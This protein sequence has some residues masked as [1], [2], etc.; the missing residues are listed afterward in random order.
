MIGF[1]PD[2]YPDELFYSACARYAKRLNYPNKLSAIIDLLGKKG[3]SATVDIPTRLDHFLSVIQTGEYSAEEIINDHTLFPFY[4]PFIT[5]ERSKI[6]REEIKQ[7]DDNRLRT[8]LAINI[9]QIGQPEYLRF[10][11]LCAESDR[12][13]FGET[14]WHRLHQLSA[15]LVCSEHRCFLENSPVRWNQ[16][17]GKVLHSAEEFISLKKPRFLD[18]S[19]LHDRLFIKIAEDARWLLNQSHLSLPNDDLRARYYNILLKMKYAWY[20]SRIKST[21]L[22]ADFLAYYPREFLDELGCADKSGEFLWLARM[23]EKKPKFVFHHPLRHLLLLNF[24]N[25]S[26]EK[27]FH[28]FVEFKPFADSP[29]PC[30]NPV[31]SHYKELIIKDCQIKDSQDKNKNRGRPL[32][33]FKCGCGFV[34]RRLGSDGSAEDKFRYDSVLEYGS[35]WESR[36]AEDWANLN[37]SLSEIARRF[38]TTNHL[39]VRHAIRL[40]LPMNTENT[41]QIE[42]YARHRSP[43]N[44]LSQNL[45][46]YR[47][48][49]ERVIT[50]HP[51]L[52]RK[53][54]L[55][56][57]KFLYQWLMRNDSDWFEKHLPAPLEADKKKDILNWK[58]IDRQL[59]EKVKRV[60][61]EILS[62]PKPTRVSITEIIKRTGNKN[63]LE[64]ADE[65]LPLTSELLEKSLESLEAFMLRKLKWAEEQYV[66]EKVMP[67]RNQ[68]MCR[69]AIRNGTT[70]NSPIIQKEVMETLERIRRRLF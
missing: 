39:I 52:N 31:S 40:N 17:V 29:Y 28:N 63:W 54:L 24:L 67:T 6:I 11:S 70:N 25:V 44:Y 50:K 51:K 45:K 1:F 61:R 42:G 30:L 69:A 38:Q 3:V 18:E 16:R 35:V 68:L 37:L 60:C 2:P 23:L 21:K 13:Q 14:Y 8:R 19:R 20:N 47:A 27:F 41:R 12:L 10:C 34:Y 4:E 32:G 22:T 26:L 58:K 7:D 15:V 55:L 64:K 59:S 36:L 65:K 56:N 66:R 43:R 49:W 46:K 5:I 48:D 53:Q 57:N 62:E 33:V 9:N